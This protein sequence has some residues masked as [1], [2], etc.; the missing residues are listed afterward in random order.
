MRLLGRAAPL[1]AILAI[2]A[3]G[4]CAT[5]ERYG[6]AKAGMRGTAE[7]VFG[8][9]SD[10]PNHPRVTETDFTRFLDEEVTPRFPDGLTVIDAQGRWSAPAGNAVEEQSKMVMIV[11]PG[12]HDDRAK[13]DAVREAYKRRYHQQSVLLM[14]HGDCVSF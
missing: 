10:D 8:R 13:L 7:L 14:T 6:C 1:A 9:S 4:G 12:H 3:L 2:S 11:L 5:P